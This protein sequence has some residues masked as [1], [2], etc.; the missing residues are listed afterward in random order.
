MK[1]ALKLLFACLTSI[2]WGQTI[3]FDIAV[4]Q[5][6]DT[7]RGSIL[8]PIGIA[9]TSAPV[10]LIIAGS[11]PTDRNG[12]NP[13][14]TNNSLLF[15]ANEL[16]K[17]KITSVR[18]DKRGVG[19][20]RNAFIPE[21][22]LRFEQNVADAQ[23]FL[24]YLITQGYSNIIV[25]GHSEGSLIGMLLAKNNPDQVKKY[26]SLA[27]AGRPIGTVLNEQYQSTMPVIRDSV[28]VVINNLE[29]GI[30]MDTISP[31]LFN[32]FR[33]NIQPYMISWMQYDPA[34]VLGTIETPS[35]IVQGNT[36]IQVSVTDADLLKKGNEKAQLAVIDQ[37]NHIFKSVSAD[38]TKNKNTYTDPN[39]PLHPELILTL[40]QFIRN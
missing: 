23:L 12:N 1:L 5:D 32:V 34:E 21:I 30:T 8:H 18:Y 31:W 6:K 20:S 14:M 27:G 29:Q 3:E 36:D 33:P 26:I 2:T 7:L 39:L 37:M 25:A 11:G 17:Y 19:A 4:T 35:L 15:L 22:D 16:A 28:K 38:K 9:D 24:D 40:V 10:V 13:V